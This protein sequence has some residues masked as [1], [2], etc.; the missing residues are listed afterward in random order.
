MREAPKLSGRE[1]ARI[2]K[3]SKQSSKRNLQGGEYTR[4]SPINQVRKS[5]A[6]TQ[7]WPGE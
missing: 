4:V 1:K 7:K 3:R 6:H 2:E 5:I